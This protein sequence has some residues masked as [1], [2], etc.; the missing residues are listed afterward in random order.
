MAAISEAP[1]LVG[2]GHWQSVR[3]RSQSLWGLGDT[4]GCSVRRPR[5]MIAS[6]AVLAA[7]P[8]VAVF[9]GSGFVG[10]RVC[11]ALNDCGLNVVSISRAGKPPEWAAAEPW[12]QQIDYSSADALAPTPIP[13]PKIDCAISCV[14]NMRPSPDWDGFFG[15]HWDTEVMRRENGE[16][17][18]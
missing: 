17:T 9:G 2:L 1:V 11:K 4:R 8:T 13:L 10:S 12:T 14:G 6:F 18:E 7:P 5:S 16:I 3:A 15:L